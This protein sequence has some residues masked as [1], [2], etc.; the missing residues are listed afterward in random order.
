MTPAP[1]LRDGGLCLR[2]AMEVACK[3]RRRFVMALFPLLAYS[4]A[5]QATE[6]VFTLI[7]PNTSESPKANGEL[8]FDISIGATATTNYVS[9]GITNSGN[10]PAIQGYIE[11]SLGPLYVNFWSSNV[12]FGEGY[13]GAEIDAAFGV[14]PEFGPL[15][16]D[17]GYVHYF[18]TPESVSPDYGELYLKADYEVESL[19]TVSGRVFFAPD[20]NQSGDTATFVAGGVKVPLPH[21]FALYG[22]VGYQFFEDPDAYE[23]LTWTAGLSYSWKSLTFDARYWDTDLSDDECLVRSGFADG[24]GSRVVFSVSFDTSLSALKGLAK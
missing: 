18:Y 8:E 15:K 13:S 16:L 9:R 17:M 10:N 22:G 19:L 2:Q 14:R 11:P 23:Q 21:D 4:G 3:S 12:D 1:N 7:P 20:F 24:C 6:S 5:V